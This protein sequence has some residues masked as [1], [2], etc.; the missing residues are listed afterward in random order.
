MKRALFAA[1]SLLSVLIGTAPILAHPT[2]TSFVVVTVTNPH[3]ATIDITTDAQSLLMKLEAFA[4]VP[5][6]RESSTA[7]NRRLTALM[8]VLLKHV[9]LLA[10]SASVRLVSGS[11]A[12]AD[13]D[14][15][16]I[17]VTIGAALPEGAR[18]LSWR[19]SLFL[20]SYPVLIRGGA[21][22]DPTDADA[23][24]WI[25]G[26]QRSSEHALA[27]LQA[28]RGGWIRFGRT[29]A[30]G[31]THILPGGLDHVLFVVGLFLLAAGTRGL[32]LQIS[33]FTVAHSVTLALAALGIVS[34]P[35]AIVEPLIAL[36]IAYVAIE[37][38]RATSLT[39]WR[40]AFVFGFGLLHGLGFAGALRDLGVSS[41]DLPLT[42]V[43][44][45]VGVELGQIAVVVLAAAAV[46]LLPVPPHRRRQW[47]AAPVSVAIAAI[48]LF[49]AVERIVLT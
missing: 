9:E 26:A 29:V 44:F 14:E 2:A 23:Y 19:S 36:S 41:S 22:T 1:T 16:R 10:D 27:D 12:A 18:A 24:E 45:N 43:G 39:R 11:I 48:G 49:W 7:R 6:S 33:A 46:R 3:T 47:I 34:V 20:E 5:S 35:S 15:Q 37:N 21:P 40:M 13:G 30:L 8:P 38:L 31:F 4:G 42:L 25:T 28:R 17:G 32:L